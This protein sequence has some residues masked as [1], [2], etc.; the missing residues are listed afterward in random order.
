MT[1]GSCR[2]KNEKG[3]YWRIDFFS[4]RDI[5]RIEEGERLNL[6]KGDRY[7]SDRSFERSAGGDL[8]NP[9]GRRIALVRK[10]SGNPF[11]G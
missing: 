7:K 4:S 1:Y 3:A 11:E 2:V 9:K 10:R 8:K 5:L 6:T